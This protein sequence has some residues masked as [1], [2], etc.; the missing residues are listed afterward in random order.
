MLINV[1]FASLS[2]ATLMGAWWAVRGVGIGYFALAS[3]VLGSTGYF[4]WMMKGV[5][6]EEHDPLSIVALFGVAAMPGAII[7]ALLSLILR[8]VEQRLPQAN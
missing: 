1:I 4:S 8:R 3:F 6:L 5:G 2:L 7:S